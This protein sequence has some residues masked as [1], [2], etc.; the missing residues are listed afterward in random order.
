MQKTKIFLTG[1]SGFVGRNILEWYRKKYKIYSPSHNELDLT[2]AEAVHAFF[3]KAPVDIVIHTANKGGNVREANFKETIPYNLKIFFNL[4]RCQE[5]FTKFI[6]LGS[7][8]EYGKQLPI[9]QFKETDFDTRV[10]I[11][12]Y[13]FYKY[14]CAK[15]IENSKGNYVNLRLFGIFGRQ[16]DYTFRFISNAI[17]KVLIGLPIAINQNVLFDFL[18]VDDFLQVIDYFINNVSKHKTYNVTP[19]NPIDLLL[20]AQLIKKLS[21][22]NVKI[23][24]KKKGLNH[25]YTGSNARLLKE[26]GDL[27][28]TS[29]EKSIKFLYEWYTKKLPVIKQ[30]L[31]YS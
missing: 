29:M 21:K 25:Q 14:I 6:T 28:F 18:Y 27:K 22:K 2:N 8:A 26:I 20:I 5:Y 23:I 15:Y 3:K 17:C 13:G 11:D 7:G 31:I 4:V 1:G 19:G 9:I 12:D 24:F 16:E 30:Q 10:P